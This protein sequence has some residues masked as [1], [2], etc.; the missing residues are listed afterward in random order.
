LTSSHKTTFSTNLPDGCELSL[1]A[2]GVGNFRLIGY[3]V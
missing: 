2:T 3:K 1:P